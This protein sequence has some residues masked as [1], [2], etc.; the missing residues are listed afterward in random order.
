VPRS[1]RARRFEANQIAI[2]RLWAEDKVQMKTAHF[3]L[4]DASCLP[5]PLQQPHP[6]ISVGANA[7]PAIERAA[8]LAIA[9]ISGRLSRSRRLSTGRGQSHD[10]SGCPFCSKKVGGNQAVPHYQAKRTAGGQSFYLVQQL[11]KLSKSLL[12]SIVLAPRAAVYFS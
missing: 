12:I 9:G 5:E 4:D 10:R 7:D 6:Q 11:D 8:R 1:H 2:K 3:E